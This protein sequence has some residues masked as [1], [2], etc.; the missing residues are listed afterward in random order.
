M[1]GG[2]KVIEV[3]DLTKVY[4]AA[5]RLFGDGGRENWPWTTSPLT[6]AAER[7]SVCSVRTAPAR[8]P[9]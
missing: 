8:P 4:P 2:E 9:P 1:N 7:S 5:A 3:K 6:S